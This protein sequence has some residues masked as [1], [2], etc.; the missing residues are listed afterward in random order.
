[1]MD[2][3]WNFELG[4]PLLQKAG[5]LTLGEARRDKEGGAYFF[6]QSLVGYGINRCLLYQGVF[7]QGCFY[8]A[9]A[10]VLSAANDQVFDS[11]DDVEI[12]LI[13]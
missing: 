10:N 1:M 2:V 11:V 13:V 12:T 6:A 9:A 8:L 5:K 4:E 3:T 7:Q